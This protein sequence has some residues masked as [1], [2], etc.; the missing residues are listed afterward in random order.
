MKLFFIFEPSNY[1]DKYL[2]GV[3]KI[4]IMNTGNLKEQYHG[5]NR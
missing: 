2:T 1:D 3:Q 4:E 5:K